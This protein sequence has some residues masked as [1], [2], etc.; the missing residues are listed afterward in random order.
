[1]STGDA[2]EAE[3]LRE[4]LLDYFEFK[5]GEWPTASVHSEEGFE[6]GLIESDLYQMLTH[7]AAAQDAEW[8]HNSFLD[9]LD[10]FQ[11]GSE[12][13]AWPTLVVNQSSGQVTGLVAGELQVVLLDIADYVNSGIEE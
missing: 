2:S 10:Y 12:E 13:E 7:L 6:E 4:R 8:L 11:L 3:E 9:L 5:E 1:M